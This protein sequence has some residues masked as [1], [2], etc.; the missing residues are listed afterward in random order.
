MPTISS[1]YGVLIRMYWDD[2]AP[3]HFHASY[4]EDEA[5][6]DIATLA[7]QR[8]ALPR[9]ATA[10]VLEWAALHRGE[11]MEDWQRCQ[12]RQELLKIAPLD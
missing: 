10:L 4:G 8:G 7:T 5:L 2:H 12:T 6:F 1:F 9:R 11:L 3:P